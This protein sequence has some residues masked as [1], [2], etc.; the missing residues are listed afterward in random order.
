MAKTFTF[1]L[2]D[3]P[4]VL[5]ER[6]KGF[7]EQDGMAFEGSIEGGSFSGKGFVG[8]YAIADS[9]LTITVTDKPF[10]APWGLV[11]SKLRSALG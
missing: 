4:E 1:A 10:I 11:E 2:K 8:S 7:A 9:T 5:L 6:V 3:S